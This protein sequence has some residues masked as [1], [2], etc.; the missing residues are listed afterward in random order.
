[1]KTMEKPTHEETLDKQM[2]TDAKCPETISGNHYFIKMPHER[3]N[4][5]TDLRPWITRCFYC[6]IVDDVE[7]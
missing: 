1:M 6:L 3:Q 7:R 4:P 5:V 2:F